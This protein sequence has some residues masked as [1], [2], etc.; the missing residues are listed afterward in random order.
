MLILIRPLIKRHKFC[1]LVNLL[2]LIYNELNILLMFQKYLTISTLGME[3]TLM[4]NSCLAFI[5]N[6][7]KALNSYIIMFLELLNKQTFSYL[8]NLKKVKI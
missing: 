5:N 4:P 1:T 8:H 6:L 2:T 7:T 3:K